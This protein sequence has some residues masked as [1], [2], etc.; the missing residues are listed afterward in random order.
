MLQLGPMLVQDVQECEECGGMGEVLRSSD[1]CPVCCGE[2]VLEEEAMVSFQVPPGLGE[3]AKIRVAD[4]GHQLPG[5]GEGGE[6]GDL[7]LC[8]RVLPHHRF[9]RRKADLL[10]EEILPLGLALGG[11]AFEL[12]I[13]ASTAEGKQEPKEQ[14]GARGERRIT[15]LLPPGE[16]IQP[17]TVRCIPGE[18]MPKEENP[19][20]RGDLVVRFQVSW[21]QRLC[22]QDAEKI[23]EILDPTSPS[24]CRDEKST[25]R[26]LGSLDVGRGAP[27]A[28]DPKEDEDPEQSQRVLKSLLGSSNLVA[29][30]VNVVY[31][32]AFDMQKFGQEHMTNHMK[33]AYDSDEDEDQNPSSTPGQWRRSRYGGFGGTGYGGCGPFMGSTRSGG[34]FQDEPPCRQM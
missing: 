6:R 26:T 15:V 24:G 23:R 3:R 9:L 33:E 14:Q 19:A 12:S 34:F 4:Q 27:A 5:I 17:G 25:P 32:A 8:C 20:L 10:T 2:K 1:L 18:G 16:V 22:E 29:D 13:L 31:L 28:M 21:P 11:G 30:G 7:V